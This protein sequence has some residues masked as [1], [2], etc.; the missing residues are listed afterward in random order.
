MPARQ[1]SE[2]IKPSVLRCRGL[3]AE[4]LTALRMRNLDPLQQL[5]TA[6]IRG[7]ALIAQK[8]LG[9]A[10][11]NLEQLKRLWESAGSKPDVAQSLTQQVAS[12]GRILGPLTP[13]ARE[14]TELGCR[15]GCNV[16]A[17]LNAQPSAES[18]S[19]HRPNRPSRSMAN[20]RMR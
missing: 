5:A 10:Q 7:A 14:P 1:R 6:A 2:A 19:A 16:L 12:L 20:G 15:C 18:R 4:A 13:K 8:R 11:L 17:A 9:L 3:D